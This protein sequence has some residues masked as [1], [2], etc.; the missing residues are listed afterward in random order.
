M[1]VIIILVVILILTR[2]SSSQMSGFT[3]PSISGAVKR[4]NPFVSF[5]P[6]PSPFSLPLSYSISH[7]LSQCTPGGWAKPENRSPERFHQ[8]LLVC[9]KEG[10]GKQD[11]FLT[12]L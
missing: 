12:F 2:L 9:R 5:P 8:L 4:L 1:V 6:S 7:L 3:Q 10:G 11:Y